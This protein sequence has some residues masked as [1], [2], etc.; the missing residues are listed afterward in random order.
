MDIIL[1]KKNIIQPG[2]VTYQWTTPK[3]VSWQAGQYGVFY[4]QHPNWDSKGPERKFS[5]SSAPHQPLAFT[6]R[7]SSS[8]FKQS[9]ERLGI[10][11]SIQLK[12]I[13]GQFA[14]NKQEAHQPLIFIAGG[15]GITPFRAML[16]DLSENNKD[17]AIHLVYIN[18]NEDFIFNGELNN[19]ANQLPNLS[20]D[21][22][23]G[24]RSLSPHNL[25]QIP[26]LADAKIFISGPT[27]FLD[28][29]ETQL[30]QA[31]IDDD[32]IEYDDFE[33]DWPA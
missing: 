24:R 12:N 4:I 10:G 13:G 2:V 7:T 19:L 11:Q 18:S 8:S 14:L 25:K 31:G 30:Q 26:T 23:I 21:F 29:V 15:I 5:I 1:A 32:A 9:L 22:L 33:E 20:L 28:H 17:A 6:T 27:P 3:P 16:V